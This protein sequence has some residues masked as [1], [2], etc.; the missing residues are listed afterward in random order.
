MEK[1]EIIEEMYNCLD[2]GNL[3]EFETQ[4]NNYLGICDVSTASVDLAMFLVKQYRSVIAD[5]IAKW[6]EIIFRCNPDLALVNF[7]FNH[8]FR[9][10]LVTGS[11]ELFE[12]YIEEAIEP[13]L[14]NLSD[15]KQKDYYNQLLRF[16]TELN[17][18]FSDQYHTQ[19]KGRDFNGALDVDD[20]NEFVVLM[21]KEDYEI[22]NE[23]VD[24]YNTI[25][26]RRNIIKALLEK[27]GHEIN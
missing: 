19:V 13:H 6:M 7:P 26:G 1:E 8:F 18:L 14:E 4:I 20:N 27:S 17:T 5:S 2:Y 23:I 25:V 12:C 9:I 10:I 11:L 24:K 3:N 16:G 22:M 21:H 15:E